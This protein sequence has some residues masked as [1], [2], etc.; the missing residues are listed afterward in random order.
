MDE[1]AKQP[2]FLDRLDPETRARIEE[3]AI[4]RTWP[5]HAS[6]FRT[7]EPCNGLHIIREGL[8]KLYRSDPSGREQIILLEGRAGV[9]AVAA[10]L[11]EGTHLATA[12]TLRRTTTLFLD[13]STFLTLYDSHTDFRDAVIH[14][15]MRRLRATV[16]LLDTLM[17]KPVPARVAG[18]VLDLASAHAALDGSR[19]FR[20]LLSQEELAHVL[21]TTRESV[22]RALSDLRSRQI[23]EQR[24][25]RIRVLD[26]QALLSFAQSSSVESSTPLPGFMQQE[27]RS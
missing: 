13:R 14:E 6:I 19:T 10:V 3:C 17:L 5:A 8:V 22:A 1:Q 20:L 4:A 23:I 11:D 27:K 18:R 12:E 21:G 24:G 25:S 16:A 15:I 7:H 9:L 2:A 26:P